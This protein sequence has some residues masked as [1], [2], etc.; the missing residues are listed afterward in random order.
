MNITLE[1]LDNNN[2]CNFHLCIF[3]AFSKG[4]AYSRH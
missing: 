2:D 4:K 1:T 3:N